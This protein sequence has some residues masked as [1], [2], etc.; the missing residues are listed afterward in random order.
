[1]IYPVEKFV[2]LYCKEKIGSAEKHQK[3]GMPI[4]AKQEVSY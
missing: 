1:V 2:G 4:T 3:I